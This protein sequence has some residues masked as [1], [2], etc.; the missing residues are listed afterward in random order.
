MDVGNSD[1]R[2][3]KLYNEHL[4]E[5]EGKPIREAARAELHIDSLDRYHTNT[6]GIA[7][8]VQTQQL[9]KLIGP[10]VTPNLSFRVTSPGLTASNFVVSGRNGRN[11][12][13]GYFERIALTQMQMFFRC[14]TII[15]GNDWQF[16]NGLIYLSYYRTIGG[17]TTTRA[18]TIPTGNYSPVALAAYMQNAIRT[19]PVLTPTAVTVNFTNGQF[20]FSTNVAG[21]TIGITPYG[22]AAPG[23]G[24]DQTLNTLHYRTAKVFGFGAEDFVIGVGGLGTIVGSTPNMLYTDYVDVCSKALTKYKRVK[25]TN[26]ADGARQDVI[27]RIYL[28]GNNTSTDPTTNSVISYN[29]SLPFNNMP[30]INVSWITPNYNK[31]SVEEVLSSV[32]FELYDMYGNPLFWTS[33]YN[34]EFQCTLTVSET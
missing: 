18:F 7:A 13:Y 1:F 22:T 5:K 27:C 12:I 29:T 3:T 26:A 16:G 19:W 2:F 9:A 30:I 15:S 21:D 25:D 20:V 34:T 6:P 23:P 17:T 11:L 31:W 28:T 14:P 32:D 8:T 4:D 33:A 10:T 24:T